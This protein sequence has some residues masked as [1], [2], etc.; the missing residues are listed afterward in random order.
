[1]WPHSLWSP[2]CHMGSSS[3]DK[4]Q[5]RKANGNIK[6]TSSYGHQSVFKGPEGLHS[7]TMATK[8]F[9]VTVHQES[10]NNCF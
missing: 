5:E 10:G 3:I 4:E 2:K 9:T 1:M 8:I 7:F 6:V